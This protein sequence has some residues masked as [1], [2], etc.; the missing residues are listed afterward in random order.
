MNKTLDV[1]VAHPDLSKHSSFGSYLPTVWTAIFQSLMES[2][3]AIKRVVKAIV[4]DVTAVYHHCI[5]QEWI[6]PDDPEKR[7]VCHQ[8]CTT[9]LGDYVQRVSY[10]INTCHNFLYA[11]LWILCMHA[12]PTVSW[13]ISN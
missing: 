5:E 10:Y 11:E 12:Y 7:T 4:D 9:I 8:L 1:V 3:A 2:G 6:D 13:L